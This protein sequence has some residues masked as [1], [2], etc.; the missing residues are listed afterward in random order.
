MLLFLHSLLFHASLS[1]FSDVFKVAFL[2][3]I[4]GQL[5]TYLD[6]TYEVYLTVF[7]PALD[8]FMD[9]FIFLDVFIFFM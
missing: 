6:I 2:K 4:I 9:V 3:K 5:N 1:L 8:M 7:L